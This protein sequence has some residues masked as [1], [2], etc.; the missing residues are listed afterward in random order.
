[1]IK[2]PTIETAAS[3]PSVVAPATTSETTPAAA[4]PTPDAPVQH[5]VPSNAWPRGDL[6]AERTE[7]TAEASGLRNGASPVRDTGG[8]ARNATDPRPVGLSPAPRSNG[9]ASAA[10]HANAEQRR[11]LHLSLGGNSNG[12]TNGGNG[13][14]RNGS[15]GHGNGGNGTAHGNGHGN[16]SSHAAADD[17][18]SRPSQTAMQ[19]PASSAASEL[20][21]PT[22]NAPAQMSDRGRAAT[23]TQSFAEARSP[24][25][26]YPQERHDGNGSARN[27]ESGS[28]FIDQDLRARVDGD[29]AVFL[30]AFDAALAQDS[31]ESRFAL[32]EATDRLLR[33]G[34][35]TRIELERMEAR[36]PLPPRDDAA[37][38]DL[39]WRHR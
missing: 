3:A 12:H 16:G 35:R 29:I 19:A 33:A 36:M 18:F 11:T 9:S 2:A 23:D 28:S 15:N 38:R 10:D 14:H 8:I 39:A 13:A 20:P 22:S 1:M 24:A 21:A 26:Q 32:R 31:Q 4:P 25:Y 17:L 27:K 7:V 30:A 34:A 6:P 37:R 5:A